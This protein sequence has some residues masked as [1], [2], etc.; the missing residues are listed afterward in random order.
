VDRRLGVYE[1][2]ARYRLGGPA[3]V[4]LEQLAGLRGQSPA[5]LRR[6]PA[7]IAVLAALLCGLGILFW[8]AANWQSLGR[9]GR[10]ALLEAS[11]C[12]ACAGAI[13]RSAARVPLGLLAL[14]AIGGLFA[15]FGQTYQTGADPW[16]LFALWSALAL[17]L[18]LGVGSDA[19]WA[20]WALV[21]M[22]AVSLWV[23][24]HTGHSWRAAPQDLAAHLLGW[25]VALTVV[26]GL[27]GV[28]RRHTGAGAWSLRTALS[29]AVLMI[30]STG[31]IG[32]FETPAGFEYGLALVALVLIV[33]FVASPLAYDIYCLSAGALGLNTLLVTGLGKM[34][35]QGVHGQDPILQLLVLG[36]AAAGL[37]AATVMWILWLSSGRAQ[38]GRS[39]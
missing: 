24:A 8:I 6:L 38:A 20:P 37:L 16:Q 26:V 34:L 32:L 4:R 36:L 31:L 3:L 30:C 22:S 18:C 29:L 19:L 9:F 27:S 23:Q 15:Y 12:A 10:F 13:W 25:L 39:A 14:L 5:L 11:L 28:L 2:A 21:T 7:A 17:P 35:L 1:L 33:L